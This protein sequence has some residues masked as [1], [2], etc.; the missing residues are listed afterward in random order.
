MV[1]PDLDI[2]SGLA[3]PIE[4]EEPLAEDVERK[5]LLALASLADGSRAARSVAVQ[6]PECWGCCRPSE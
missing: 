2:I 5:L 4:E 3:P 6:V 1:L